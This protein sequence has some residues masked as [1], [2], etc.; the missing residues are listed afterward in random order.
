[1]ESAEQ[2]E[3]SLCSENTLLRQE[4]QALINQIDALHDELGA[5]KQRAHQSLTILSHTKAGH[6]TDHDHALPRQTLFKYATVADK[7]PDI[8]LPRE[9]FLRLCLVKDSAMVCI[10][11]YKRQG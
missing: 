4:N 6:A 2:N 9:I 1:M 8:I 3:I 10:S 5:W 11:C 7:M